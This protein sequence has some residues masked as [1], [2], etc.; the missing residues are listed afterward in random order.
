M[1]LSDENDFYILNI[2]SLHS[3]T[4][5]STLIYMHTLL[6]VITEARLNLNYISITVNA[7]HNVLLESYLFERDLLQVCDKQNSHP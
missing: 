1:V 4:P 3:K 5:T 6:L 2:K 7:K